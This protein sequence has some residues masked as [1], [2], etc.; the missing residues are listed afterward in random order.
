MEVMYAR[1]RKLYDHIHDSHIGIP[2]GFFGTAPNVIV[3][4]DPADAG[5][6][7][8]GWMAAD[9]TFEVQTAAPTNPTGTA[10]AEGTGTALMRA[11][12]TIKQ[13]IVTTKGDILGHNATVPARHAVGANTTV[14]T[15][16][17]AQTTGL[18]WV[19]PAAFAGNLLTTVGDL[20][21]FGPASVVRQGVGSDGSVIVADS[22]QG[23]GWKWTQGLPLWTKVTVGHSAFHTAAMANDILLYN[24]PAGGVIHAV[25]T[26]T[27]QQFAGTGITDYKISVGIV[28]NLTKYSAAFDVDT[29]VSDTNF[30]LSTTV[31]SEDH[32]SVVQIRIAATSAGANLDQSTTGSVTVW[33]LVS[34]AI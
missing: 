25:K 1:L 17:S 7:N 3:A 29:A 24:L 26:K 30:Q 18:A 10:A 27:V 21:T 19:T 32:G 4:G 6:E 14:L 12:A 23:T 34:V 2:G 5:T 8:A 9:A 13:G 33:L 22:A 31:G 28:G 20:L 16:D 15:A 11:D